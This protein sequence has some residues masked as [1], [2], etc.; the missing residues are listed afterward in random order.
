MHWTWV[1]GDSN[2]VI[3]QI[4]FLWLGDQHLFSVPHLRDDFIV[5]KVGRREKR[6]FA[7]ATLLCDQPRGPEHAAENTA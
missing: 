5:D 3:E 7:A 2:A 1:L 6:D 4:F